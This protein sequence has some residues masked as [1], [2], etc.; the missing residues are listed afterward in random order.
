M[1]TIN[2]IEILDNY[3]LRC[4]FSNNIVKVADVSIYLDA[5]AFAILKN[6]AVF[7]TVINKNYFVEWSDYELDL[8]A[9]TLWH[10]GAEEVQTELATAN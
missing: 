2:N 8:S 1:R 5:P 7:D 9:D 10:I 4:T 6:K 3:K